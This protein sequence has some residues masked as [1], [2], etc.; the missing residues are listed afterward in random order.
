MRNAIKATRRRI[1]PRFSAV[2]LQYSST[3]SGVSGASPQL[4]SGDGTPG[5]R[6]IERKS[7][8]PTHPVRACIRTEA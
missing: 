8:I 5:T 3:C 2:L 6:R 4:H 1:I 7:A